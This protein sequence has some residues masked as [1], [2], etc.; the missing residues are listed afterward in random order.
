MHSH[1]HTPRT[2]PAC[3]H[4]FPV[5]LVDAPD[6]SFFS[7]EGMGGPRGGPGP[8]GGPGGPMGGMRPNQ[9]GSGG[10]PRGQF[11]R[12]PGGPGGFN[13]QQEMLM[14]AQQMQNQ[15]M[16]QRS[17]GAASAL[18]AGGAQQRPG[19]GGGGGGGDARHAGGGPG[20]AAAGGKLTESQQEILA[21]EAKDKA[22]QKKAKQWSALSGKICAHTWGGGV[23]LRLL[24]VL[25]HTIRGRWEGG[26][27]GLSNWNG[28]CAWQSMTNCGLIG[29]SR[30]VRAVATG[31]RER[32]GNVKTKST[33]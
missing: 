31:G 29:V 22:L 24:G 12:P 6:V 7:F 15:Q 2:V 8:M 16:Q 10:P 9:V 25:L 30:D 28:K 5:V 14:R 20:G 19:G 13:P 4:C 23:R 18:A 3:T 27:G 17:Q 26:G 1:T 32:M 21:M 33:A 11:G